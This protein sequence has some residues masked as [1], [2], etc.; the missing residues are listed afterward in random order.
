MFH[1]EINA[2]NM[3]VWPQAFTQWGNLNLK[4]VFLLFVCSEPPQ[5]TFNHPCLIFN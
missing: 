5:G 4:I 2:L 1:Q 3:C